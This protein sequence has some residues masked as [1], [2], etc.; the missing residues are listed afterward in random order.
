MSFYLIGEEG[1]LEGTIIHFEK[2]SEWSIGR[3]PAEVDFVLEDP[4]VS[5]KH[6]V[7]REVDGGIVFEN[8]STVNPATQDGKIISDT[9]LL[10]EG[11]VI[12]IGGSFFRFSY[13]PPSF[14][15][16]DSSLIDYPNE[17][18]TARVSPIVDARWLIKT[19]KGPNNGAEFYMEVNRSYVL[20]KDPLNSDLIF[21]DVSVSGKHARI[22]TDDKGDPSIEDLGSLNGTF[23]GNEKVTSLRS[24]RSEDIVTLGNSSFIVIDKENSRSTIATIVELPVAMA[25]SS[26]EAEER[27]WR[28]MIIPKKFIILGGVAAILFLFGLIGVRF[29]FQS[30][31]VEISVTGEDTK[32]ASLIEKYPSVRYV[33]REGSGN[34]FV[35]G[36]VLTSVEKQELLYQLKSLP[37]L[38]N[39]EDTVIVDE[40]VWDAINVLLRNNA[41]WQNISVYSSV[42]GLFVVEGYVRSLEQKQA[43]HDYLSVHFPYLS[44]F[45]DQVFV[46]NVLVDQIQS[47][48]LEKGF[49]NI[50]YQLVEGELIFSGFLPRS[51]EQEFELLTKK[52]QKLQG[53]RVV[54]VAVVYTSEA[55]ALIDLSTKYKIMG[56]S[57]KGGGGYCVLIDGKLLSCGDIL[58]GMVVVEITSNLVLLEKDG[59]KYKIHYNSQ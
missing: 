44:Q 16:T 59:L 45:D 29:L 27:N 19:I 32:I 23:V 20:G 31:I 36:N 34:L 18:A 11:N 4:M 33:Y 21:Q 40:Y 54:K 49:N 28:E 46:E 12:Q 17:L 57:K 5:R 30:R 3:D 39:I 6:A 22:V 38:K 47:L 53:I 14:Q 37:F 2:G 13:N 1:P 41:E 56:Y 48:I 55:R 9:V 58:D 8:L 51:D 50:R 24:L 42:A 15:E 7:C 35:R 10:K 43:L 25:P 52:V 26:S